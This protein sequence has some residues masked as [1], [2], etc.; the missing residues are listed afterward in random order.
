M[1]KYYDTGLENKLIDEIISIAKRYDVDKLVLFGSRARGDYKEKSD[2]D[3]AFV[4]GMAGEFVISVN[5]D[6]ETLLEFDLVN[7][8]KAVQD[9]LKKVIMRE[10]IT[11]YE[12]V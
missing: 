3:I 12:K 10:G 9:D 11:I 4:G 6:T 7:L 8:S 2:I 1:D 5:E